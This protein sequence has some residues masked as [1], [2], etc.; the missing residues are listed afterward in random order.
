MKAMPPTEQAIRYA[1][2][3][4][5]AKP[6]DKRVFEEAVEAIKLL[7]VDAELQGLIADGE[8]GERRGIPT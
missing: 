7:V 8:I 6:K 2:A 3:S 5:A 1:L 4:V